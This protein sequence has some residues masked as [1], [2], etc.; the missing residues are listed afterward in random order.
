MIDSDGLLKLFTAYLMM[1]G[2]AIAAVIVLVRL[3]LAI[4]TR[5][6]DDDDEN[7]APPAPAPAPRPVAPPEWAPPRPR[8]INPLPEQHD[9]N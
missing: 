9:G 8:I 7:T 5:Q 4:G 6:D 2:A 1:G 3:A